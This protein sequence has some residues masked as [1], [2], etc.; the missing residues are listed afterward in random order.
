[1]PHGLSVTSIAADSRAPSSPTAFSR[2]DN[3]GRA[4]ENS[5]LLPSPREVPS[6]C[7]SALTSSSVSPIGGPG[8]L[9]PSASRN[10]VGSQPVKKMSST[11]D[12]A[13]SGSNRPRPPRAAITASTRSSST[14]IVGAGSPRFTW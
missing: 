5:R 9:V 8:A 7:T 12:L 4:A 3:S 2:N 10:I 11:S 13:S 1:V 14:W 6:A